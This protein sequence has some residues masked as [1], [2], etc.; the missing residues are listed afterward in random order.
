M[1]AQAHSDPRMKAFVLLLGVFLTVLVGISRVYLGV[2]WP[3][4]VV[5]G[6]AL[7]LAWAAGSWAAAVCL[8]KMGWIE[9]DAKR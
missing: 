1:L 9:R 7:G 8:Q 6:W 5:A 2:H 3:T 4:D